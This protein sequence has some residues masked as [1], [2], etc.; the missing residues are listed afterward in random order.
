[1]TG[2][3]ADLK[4]GTGLPLISTSSSDVGTEGS[5]QT[6]SA[7]NVGTAS[8]RLQ[9]VGSEEGTASKKK[10]ASAQEGLPASVSR[11]VSVSADLNSHWETSRTQ[12]K[13]TIIKST[14]ESTTPSSGSDFVSTLQPASTTVAAENSETL[15]TT[16]AASPQTGS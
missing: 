6:V 8:H 12:E 15:T 4:S 16:G 3:I 10:L 13:K 7:Q 9:R 2:S 11:P 14:D 1:M 5:P